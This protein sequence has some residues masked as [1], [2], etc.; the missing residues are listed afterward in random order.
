VEICQEYVQSNKNNAATSSSCLHHMGKEKRG[1]FAPREAKQI[2]VRSV[3]MEQRSKSIL[4]KLDYSTQRD[5]I[6]PH[7]SSCIPDSSYHAFLRP[8]RF[9]VKVHEPDICVGLWDRLSL[10][11]YGEVDESQKELL[12]IES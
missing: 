12:Q 5:S 4:E 3:E 6:S 11:Q 9:L 2:F 7:R 1:D 10:L 8:S